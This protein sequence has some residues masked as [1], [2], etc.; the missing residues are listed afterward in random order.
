VTVRTATPDDAADLVGLLRAGAL[1]PTG[2]YHDPDLGSW[3]ETLTNLA[4]TPG[5]DVLVAE[6]DGRVAGTCQLI[7]FRHLQ[8]GG[9][10]CAELESM[11]VAP[12]LRG[13]GVGGVL[14]EAAVERARA[15]G[16]YR[17]QLTSN[18]ARNDAHRFYERHGFT[19][20]HVGYKRLLGPPTD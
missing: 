7:V 10:W 16:C 13:S 15:A 9:G 20:S 11:H 18:R 4:A 19:P 12:D 1:V 3:R 8:H 14:L 6:V 17:V 2:E 5:N